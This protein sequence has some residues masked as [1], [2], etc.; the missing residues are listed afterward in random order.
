MGSAPTSATV[1]SSLEQPIPLSSN[2]KPVGV[3][4]EHAYPIRHAMLPELANIHKSKEMKK[5]TIN[6]RALSNNSQMQ[7]KL[8]V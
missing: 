8:A 1:N 3:R 5:Y 2:G 4:M 6:G 7:A